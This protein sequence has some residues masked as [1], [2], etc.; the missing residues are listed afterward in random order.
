M[1]YAKSVGENLTQVQYDGGFLS[2]LY[3]LIV[4]LSQI[5]FI[6]FSIGTVI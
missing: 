6:F 5:S 2:T 4:S 1:A 3:R